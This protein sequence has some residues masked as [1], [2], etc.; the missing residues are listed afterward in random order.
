MDVMH[1]GVGDFPR[2]HRT[3]EHQSSTKAPLR[4]VDAPSLSKTCIPASFPAPPSGALFPGCALVAL[5]LYFLPTYTT[6]GARTI[7]FA[8]K[9]LFSDPKSPLGFPSVGEGFRIPSFVSPS[10]LILLYLPSLAGW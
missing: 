9:P 10:P 4:S 7:G 1:T 8:H 6:Q 3:R 5:R 2:S